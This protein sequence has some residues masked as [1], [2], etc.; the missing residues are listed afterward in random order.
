MR[1]FT[2][3]AAP[4]AA[5]IGLAVALA[6]AAGASTAHPLDGGGSYTHTEPSN[7]T[8]GCGEDAISTEGLATETITTDGPHVV[9]RFS[10][11]ELGDGYTFTVDGTEDFWGHKPWYKLDDLKGTWF[12][13]LYPFASF[14]RDV[15]VKVFATP[16]GE[17]VGFDLDV[18]GP[19]CG[20]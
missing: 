3:R 20:P 15:R 10:D 8:V 4:F 19:D 1:A 9:V 2:R 11:V 18:E 14:E 13:L 12:N 17:P 6:P 5:L 7:T 16:W